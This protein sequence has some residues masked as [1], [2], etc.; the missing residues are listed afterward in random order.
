MSDTFQNSFGSTVK[1]LADYG[2]WTLNAV[3][4]SPQNL[5]VGVGG[6]RFPFNT[7]VSG[8]F[9]DYDTT[10]H[11][12]TVTR[13]G[14]YA[15]SWDGE[16]NAGDT[17]GGSQRQTLIQMTTS[18]LS[19]IAKE[20]CIMQAVATGVISCFGISATR[21]LLVADVIEFGMAQNGTTTLPFKASSTLRISLIQQYA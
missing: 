4:N 15:M 6:N 21:L 16:L 18:G 1:P 20:A 5:D 10:T 12:F 9:P 3:F 8:E 17:A 14:L 11:K 13:K 7:L 19:T 2:I